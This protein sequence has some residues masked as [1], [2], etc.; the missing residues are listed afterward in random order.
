MSG[1]RRV[2]S[3]SADVEAD[4]SPWKAVSLWMLECAEGSVATAGK[5]VCVFQ[6]SEHP[7]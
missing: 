6:G 5:H 2:R 4:R 1:G 3:N 7:K